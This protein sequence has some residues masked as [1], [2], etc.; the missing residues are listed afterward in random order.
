MSRTKAELRAY[1]AGCLDTL[2]NVADALDELAAATLQD[3]PDRQDMARE[4][5]E[6]V[7]HMA[8]AVGAV[9][10]LHSGLVGDRP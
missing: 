10:A 9:I 7:R 3:D 8:P 2:A 1:R 4:L 5:A 6:A